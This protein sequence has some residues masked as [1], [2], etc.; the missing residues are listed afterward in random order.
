MLLDFLSACVA[1]L[2]LHSWLQN[3]PVGHQFR[4]SFLWDTKEAGARG[5]RL[6]AWK[7]TFWLPHSLDADLL[8]DWFKH[9]Q[10]L[11]KDSADLFEGHAFTPLALLW[12]S[13][14]FTVKSTVNSLLSALLA[15]TCVS[16]AEP[17]SG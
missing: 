13:N 3:D 16:I 17:A 5:P 10:K 6:T 8:L 11:L 14:P 4:T 15:I 7:F 1:W 9:T 2:R 12:E